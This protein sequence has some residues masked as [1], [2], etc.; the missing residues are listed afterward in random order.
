M[1]FGSIALTENILNAN[2]VVA[3]NNINDNNNA[4]ANE[5]KSIININDDEQKNYYSNH[6]NFNEQLASVNN[7]ESTHLLAYSHEQITSLNNNSQSAL[8]IH[9]NADR[10]PPV[11]T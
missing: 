4:N 8:L 7:A 3:V 5:G 11:I 1:L 2:D 9:I 6:S 10:A